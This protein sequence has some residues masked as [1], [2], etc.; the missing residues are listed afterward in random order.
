M[1]GTQV[2]AVLAGMALLLSAC[3][4]PPIVDLPPA[5]P[6]APVI[7]QATASPESMALV[8]YFASVETFLQ[9][10]GNL[11]TDGGGKGTPFDTRRITDAFMNIAFYNEF[12]TQG[13]ASVQKKT[14]TTLARWTGP[15][16]AKIEFGA[17][18]DP[19]H[20]ARDQRATKTYLARLATLSGIPVSTTTGDTAN[21]LIMFV[22]EDERRAALP[23]IQAFTG[24]IDPATLATIRDPAKSTYCFALSVDSND[25]RTIEKALVII[26]AE[27]PDLLRLSCIHEELAQMMGL[28]NDDPAARPSIFNDD[29]E[30]AT[31]TRMDEYL[32]RILYDARLTPGLTE[33][34]ARPIVETI[35][36]DLLGQASGS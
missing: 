33:Q 28:T 13:G 4:Q 20:L 31:L 1:T 29:E 10:Q 30:F 7:Q 23:R 27:T 9:T 6:P 15:I 3:T 26:R 24:G 5:E 36:A 34:Q 21:V 25:D 11:R 35:A 12:I 16:T 2:Q 18:T 19:A 32:M 14:A 22:N 17:L 8:K